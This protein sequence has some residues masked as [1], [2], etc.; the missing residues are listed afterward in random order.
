MAKPEQNE[1]SKKSD[2]THLT[3]KAAQIAEKKEIFLAELKH[4]GGIVSQAREKA[5]LHRS[6]LYE[7]FK[8]DRVFADR[9]LE[10]TEHGQD[11][12]WAEARRRATTGDRVR[13]GTAR[14]GKGIYEVRRSDTLLIF[15]IKSG[16]TTKKW[17]KRLQMAGT[18][19]LETVR[20]SG[21]EFKLTEEQITG[22]QDAVL[23]AFGKVPMA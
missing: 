12:L 10:A 23:E 6:T 8:E 3:P 14:D 11:E 5:K 7:H 1:H 18:E 17:R 2:L 21:N 13:V 9:W 20:R 4:N 19:A 22:I 15:L 16:E